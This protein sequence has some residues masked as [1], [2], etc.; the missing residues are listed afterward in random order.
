MKTKTP[1]KSP[2]AFTLVELMV[3]VV[4]LS[5]LAVTILPKFIGTTYDAKVSTAKSN[6]AEL[7]SAVERFYIH[8]DRYPTTQEGLEVLIHAPADNATSWRGPYIERL[9]QDP[10]GNAYQYLYPGTHNPNSYDI[11]SRGADGVDGGTD[12]GADI[13]NW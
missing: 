7:Q 11:W 5:I 10:W 1:R 3:V 12:K 9:R 13:G 4:I 6:V 8:M 2:A